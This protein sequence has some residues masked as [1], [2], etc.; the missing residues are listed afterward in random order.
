MSSPTCSDTTIYLPED[1][2]NMVGITVLGQIPDINSADDNYAYWTVTEEGA[3]KN[4]KE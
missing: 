2:E 3:A 4:E 1:I